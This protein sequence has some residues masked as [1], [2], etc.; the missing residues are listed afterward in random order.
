M[1]PRFPPPS[2]SHNTATRDV[3]C[4]SPWALPQIAP[5]SAQLLHGIFLMKW[6]SYNPNPYPRLF[7]DLH[8][9]SM[10][11]PTTLKVQVQ[12]IWGSLVSKNSG[13][14][15]KVS[16]LTTQHSVYSPGA[17]LHVY[18]K[19]NRD[20]VPFSLTFTDC[21]VKTSHPYCLNSQ[22]LFLNC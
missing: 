12:G 10:L 3:V 19:T 18:L 1:H 11:S 7:L 6:P 14:K 2:P 16:V 13:K 21:I 5:G 9:C 4:R 8:N 15:K 20:S 17:T 22:Y